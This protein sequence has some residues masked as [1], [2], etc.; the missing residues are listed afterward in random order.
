MHQITELYDTLRF[1]I[2]EVQKQLAGVRR[3]FETC[4]PEHAEHS[5]KYVDYID[6]HHINLLNRATRLLTERPD[7]DVRIAVQ[8]YEHINQGL[9]SLSRQLQAIVFQAKQSQPA[10]KLLRKKN[11][12]QALN[13]LKAGLALIEPA[14][15]SEGSTLAIDICRLKVHID[16]RCDQQL[17]KYKARLKKGQQTAALL[18][19]CFI[20]R[21]ISAMGES[22]L[23]IGEG[24]ISAN[25]GQMIQIE[26][27]HSL[28][29]TLSALKLSPQEDD[30]SI[31]AMGETKSG[32]TI[33]GIMSAEESEG[34][35]LAIFKEGDKTKL[36]EEKTGIESWHQKFP[37]IAPKVYSYHKNGDKAAL[38]FEYLTGETFDKLLLQ[39]D[40][41]TLKP[42]LTKLFETLDQIWAETRTDQPC[43]AHYM[44]QLRKRLKNIYDV[45][46]DFKS[47]SVSIS[48]LKSA[49]LETLIDEAEV[50][51]DRLPVPCGV[52]IHGDFN[53]DNIIYDPV[54]NDINFIDLHRSDYL[55]FVQDLSVLMV[56]AYR[57]A[58]FDPPVRKLIAQT[59]Q[60]IYSFGQ[61]YAERIDDTSYHLR[62]ALG[63]SRSF[64]TSTRFVLDKQHAKAMHFRGRYLIEQVIRLT[65]E[66]QAHYRIPREIFHD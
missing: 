9:K 43:P 6:N 63:L 30:L 28:E 35:I 59:M 2:I 19:S 51:E 13:D 16:K 29:A 8:S 65:D 26:R 57:L 39:K 31:R 44:A 27:Y 32:C 12:F 45:H 48:G 47:P 15:E 52:Y 40:R 55:D 34:Q 42:A 62:M 17:E 41:K 10:L 36:K 61:D 49:T 14:I 58:N 1:L 37:G 24:I 5:L 7:D 60:A 38:L 66:E 20:L 21:D 25:L 53:L 11:V 50:L 46:P 4:E 56:S 3:F 23:R 54:D 18:Q 33:S 22:L 64:L